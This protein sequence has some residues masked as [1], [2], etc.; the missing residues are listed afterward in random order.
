M[1]DYFCLVEKYLSTLEGYEGG[2]GLAYVFNEARIIISKQ[3]T[4]FILQVPPLNH[5]EKT[6]IECSHSE[7]T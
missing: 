6:S 3:I 4:Y 2:V 1:C 5:V 7:Q